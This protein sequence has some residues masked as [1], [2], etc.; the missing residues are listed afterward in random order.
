[1][2][3]NRY[4]LTALLHNLH[5]MTLPISQIPTSAPHSGWRQAVVRKFIPG[6]RDPFRAVGD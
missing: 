6:E 4:L 3:A 1:M 2:H 5:H